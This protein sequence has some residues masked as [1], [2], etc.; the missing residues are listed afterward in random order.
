PEL[1]FAH[2]LCSGDTWS[3]DYDDR[4]LVNRLPPTRTL[5]KDWY[6]LQGVQD[7][8]CSVDSARRFLAGMPKAHLIEVEGRGHGF[9]RRQSWGAPF[10]KA[11]QDLWTEKEVK[12]PAA[13]PRSA[14]TRE[15]EGELQRLQLPLEY[16][17]PAQLT[18]LLLFFSGDGGWASL[19]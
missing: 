4:R 10:D 15:M 5:P 19:D 14:T 6:V 16:R 8:V 1:H 12:P 13:Q 17:W 2:E 7:Q 9:Y 11:L 18:S 3:P